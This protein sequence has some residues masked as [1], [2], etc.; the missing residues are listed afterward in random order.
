MNIASR[1]PLCLAFRSEGFVEE[2]RSDFDSRL[3][4][5][6]YELRV[7]FVRPVLRSIL[8]IIM[9]RS[10]NEFIAVSIWCRNEYVIL[11]IS[12]FEIQI[13]LID[14]FEMLLFHIWIKLINVNKLSLKILIC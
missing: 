12:S 6:L 1:R 2:P 10:M 4:F 8:A 11:D 9:L 3:L 7:V 5:S 14:I 13:I